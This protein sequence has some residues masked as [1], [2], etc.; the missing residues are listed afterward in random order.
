V[1]S[2]KVAVN[3]IYG[4]LSSYSHLLSISS[5][6]NQVETSV[7]QWQRDVSRLFMADYPCWQTEQA[8]ADLS[9]KE[10]NL[11]NYKAMLDLNQFVCKE[12]RANFNA[13]WLQEQAKF[14]KQ[15]TSRNKLDNRDFNSSYQLLKNETE[16]LISKSRLNW[17]LALLSK[18]RAELLK[19]LLSNLATLDELFS[20]VNGLGLEPGVLLD[21]SEGELT[22]TDISVV[23][24][25][26][27]YLKDDQGVQDLL[28]LMGR[29]NQIKRSEKIEVVKKTISQKTSIPDVNSKEE[30]VGIKLG[31]DLEHAL[32][33]E[34]ALMGDDE[35]SI[36]FD[37]KYVESG[38]M[39][40]DMEGIQHIDEK[41]EIDVEQSIEEKDQKGPM[42]I[43]I[44]TSGSMQGAPETIAKAVTMSMVLQANQ[45]KRDCYLINF[46]TSIKTLDLSSGFSM[47]KLIS[48][49]QMSF[50]GG[51]DV[52][53]A[54]S[55]GISVMNKDKYQNADM[56]IISD[57]IMNGLPQQQLKDIKLLRERGN[58][59]N[60][61]VVDHCF[62]E[63]RLKTV[64]DYEW[65]YDPSSSAVIE[66]IDFERAVQ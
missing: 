51:T 32:P 55:H 62:M 4:S 21:L 66:L 25:W 1:S 41:H 14:N 5:V 46:S 13:F 19:I 61:L 18:K 65:V 64:F 20:I 47:K 17:E 6:N 50:Y 57:F 58:K 48:F 54:I 49:L 30:I 29:L 37:L 60:S 27:K 12:V 44:D 9:K 8:F 38:I 40:F 42:V 52:A 28:S 10:C 36:L 59:F 63:H 16:Q 56:L 15:Y 34:L 3:E 31:K 39:C 33:S 24:R 26:L 2:I 7:E 53:P 45:E 22:K 35:A 11:V 23:T 43:C